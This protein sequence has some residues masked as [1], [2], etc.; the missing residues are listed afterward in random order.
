VSYTQTP[1]EY[2]RKY[3]GESESKTQDILNASKGKVLIVDDAH[4]FWFGESA[5][6]GI[7]K[8]D[9]YW[10]GVIDTFVSNI[11]NRPREDRC[12]IFLGYLD[13]M[14]EMFP[15]R[16]LGSEAPISARAGIPVYELQR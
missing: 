14:E 9:N 3:I 5:G 6:S 15:E 16:Q 10:L 12:V 1:D 4:S 11:H 7:S 8:S 13:Q 2:V